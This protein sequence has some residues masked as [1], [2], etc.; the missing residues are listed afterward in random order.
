M[1]KSESKAVFPRRK[2]TVSPC[3]AFSFFFQFCTIV[4]SQKVRH[5]SLGLPLVESG[6]AGFF[7]ESSPPT[8]RIFSSTQ[9]AGDSTQ[10]DELFDYPLCF[11][12]DDFCAWSN[13]SAETAFELA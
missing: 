2:R 8:F 12:V 4:G 7:W 5:V 3:S 6:R 9:R 13:T 10:R 11:L 1:Q